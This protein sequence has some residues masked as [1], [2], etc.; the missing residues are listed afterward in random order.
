MTSAKQMMPIVILQTERLTLRAFTEA[1]IDDV[2]AAVNDPEIQRWLP[3]PEPGVPYT[4]DEAEAWCRTVAP[5]S[6]VT[7]DGQ[8]WAI[9][10]RDTG[11]FCGSIGFT[12]TMWVTQ[13]TEI[14]YWMA[15][16]ARGRGLA[17]E[18][19]IAA[20]RWAIDQ[21]FERIVLRAATANTGSRRVAEKAGFVFEGIERN[22]MRLHE[23][24][25]DMALYSLI[26]TDLPR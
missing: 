25:C 18:A 26:P 4:H 17:A 15:P 14:G 6:R 3:L 21:G 22:A 8:K 24:R 19:T 20:C 2:F 16:W 5:E 7:G 9:I 23:G 12:R 13:T 1:D 10:E 11:R